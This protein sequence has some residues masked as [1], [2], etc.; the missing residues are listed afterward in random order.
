M[1]FCWKNSQ[2]NEEFERIFLLGT[3]LLQLS[4]SRENVAECSQSKIPNLVRAFVNDFNMRS[5]IFD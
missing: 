4:V 2:E 5:V 1:I 3:L